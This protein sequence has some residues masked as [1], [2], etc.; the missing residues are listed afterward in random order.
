MYTRQRRANGCATTQNDRRDVDAV[1]MA[2]RRATA[3][4][5][6]ACTAVEKVN[7]LVPRKKGT[8]KCD[9]RQ[10]AVFNGVMNVGR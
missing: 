9:A 6:C 1:A 8:K 7:Q 4:R 3:R 10:K 2:W 5:Y